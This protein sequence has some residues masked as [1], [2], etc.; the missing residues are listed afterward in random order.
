MTKEEAKL[1][2]LIIIVCCNWGN[3]NNTQQS[4]VQN[5]QAAALAA[6]MYKNNQRG[7]IKNNFCSMG[8]DDICLVD[9]VKLPAP[10]YY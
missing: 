8:T 9:G 5:P 2:S 3:F 7:V 6:A 1:A 4:I 10:V